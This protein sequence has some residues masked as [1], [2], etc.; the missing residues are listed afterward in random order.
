MKTLSILNN[1][2]LYRADLSAGVN[3]LVSG[4]NTVVQGERASIQ[5]ALTILSEQED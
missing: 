4:E 1:V 2:V 5:L 3:H